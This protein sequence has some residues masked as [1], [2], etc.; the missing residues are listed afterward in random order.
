MIFARHRETL[1]TLTLLVLFFVSGFAALVYQ[2]L[3]VREL[4]LLFG[5]TA[6]AAAMTIGVFFSGIAMGS[7]LFGRIAPRLRSSLLGFGL[8]E[9]GVAVTALGHF[10]LVDAYH[11]AYPAIYA[12]AGHSVLLDTLV[13]ALVAATVLLPPAFLMGGTLPL[14]AQHL[15]RSRDRLG[16]TGSKLYAVNTAG[17]ASGALAAGFVLPLA[18]GF[19]N[20]YLFAVGL[21]LFVG[22]AATAIAWGERRHAG[23]PGP[24]EVPGGELAD[25]PRLLLPG[26]VLS[27][28]LIG[29][30]AFASGFTT[31]ATEVLW[32]R[33]FAQVLQNSAH[34]Y[35]LVLSTFLVALALGATLANLLCRIERWSAA[36]LLGGLLLLSGLLTAVSPWLFYRVTGGFGYLG[37]DQGWY[38]YLA[39]VGGVAL[40]VMGLPGL[41]LGAV[42]PYLLRVLEAQRQ[43]PGEVIGRLVA[44]NTVGAILGAL[45]GGFLLLPLLGVWHALLLLAA[46]YLSLLVALLLS[47]PTAWRVAGAG[48]ATCA[49]LGLVLA[50]PLGLPGAPIGVRP[51]DR[52]VLEVREGAHAT[53]AAVE[54]A[55]GHRAIRVNTYYTLGSS[56]ALRPER[57]Q[58]A[59]PLLTHPDPRAVFFLGM[60][61][62][63]TAGASLAFPVQ[64]VV[65]AEILPEVVSL[66]AAHFTPWTNGLFDDPRVVVHAEDGRNCLSRSR[67]AF[68]V[69]ISD[70]FTPW[71]A[72]TGNLYTY[73]HYRIGL[74]RLNPGG[75]YVQWLP[76]YQVSEQEF[77]IIARTMDAVFPQVLLWRGDFYPAR[78][79]VA[80]VGQREAEPLDPRVAS[81]HG[82]YALNTAGFDDADFTALILR[83]YVGNLTASRLFD[84]YPINTDHHPWIEHLAPR[85]HR[86]VRAGEATFLV[87]T[88]R[89]TLYHRLQNEV[90]PERD[91]Y[92]TE[93]TATQ[94][95]YVRAGF[96]LSWASHL[97]HTGR[98][99]A[100]E[101]QRHQARQRLPDKLPWRS[102][103]AAFLKTQLDRAGG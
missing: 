97:E 68:D 99:E 75:L 33:L 58:T 61:T 38:G 102:T 90:P 52:R 49:A 79:I 55:G 81:R 59:V 62:G 7:W 47:P 28:R 1:T 69:I 9:I 77:G 103:P 34:T 21:D 25:P 78:S 89:E 23:Q 100:A 11:A 20:A 39:R 6:Q 12:V 30:I 94:R 73:Q 29:T 84:D 35:A 48:L 36:Q 41:I 66:A 22:L 65:V 24:F 72:G 53:V 5:S 86:R 10:V 98:A 16:R 67:E 54:V 50:R 2:V 42:L 87:G 43:A 18:L 85:T 14:M 71:K 31:L 56:R 51:G 44:V 64:R 46:V 3:W 92:L 74:E 93:L 13:K 17:S 101:A 57:D 88:A 60:G 80:L 83:H 82:R 63:I 32:T 37:G 8:V 96:E 45:A 19:R 95:D 15:V 40:I 91:P 70:L 4:G 27:P 26:R 76:L